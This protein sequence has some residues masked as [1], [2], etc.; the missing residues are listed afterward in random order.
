MTSIAKILVL[1][2]PFLGTATLS[3]TKG[4]PQ[5]AEQKVDAIIAT[6]YQSAETIMPCKISSH[7]GSHM[8]YWQKVDQCLSGAARR[9]DWDALSRQLAAVRPP[10]VSVDDFGAAVEASLTRQALP[11]D[12]VFL[13]KDQKALLPLTNS[14]LKY[15]TPNV[16]AGLPVVDQTGKKQLGT[17]ANTFIHEAPGGLSTSKIFALVM[18]Q[19]KDFQGK[20]Q[21]P[22]ERNLLDSYGVPWTKVSGLAAF[23]LTSEKMP[24]FS[25]R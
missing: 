2:F 19:Y 11:Y 16:L 13:V 5:E 3:V 4:M 8:L 22:P 25:D 6:A 18:F 17:F 1:I 24:A 7:S 21:M 15:L 10:S 14:L 23:R 20:L 12:K 9:V